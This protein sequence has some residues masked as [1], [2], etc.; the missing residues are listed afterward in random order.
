MYNLS[1]VENPMIGFEGDASCCG[2]ALKSPVNIIII[3][4]LTRSE[5]T[6]VLSSEGYSPIRVFT[7]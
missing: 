6:A 4:I 5:A 3:T 1:P 7:V 2:Q